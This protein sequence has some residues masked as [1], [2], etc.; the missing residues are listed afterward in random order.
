MKTKVMELRE[1]CSYEPKLLTWIKLPKMLNL[2]Q[3]IKKWQVLIS[4]CILEQNLETYLERV[5]IRFRS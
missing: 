5:Q 2:I 3:E 1:S 4:S